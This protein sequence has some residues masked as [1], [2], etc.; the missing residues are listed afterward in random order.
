MYVMAPNDSAAKLTRLPLPRATEMILEVSVAVSNKNAKAG[1]ASA[2]E[3]LGVRLGL[4]S[5]M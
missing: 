2:A 4:F 1:S 3:S 5:D